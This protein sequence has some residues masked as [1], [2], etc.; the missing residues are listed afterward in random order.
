[1]SNRGGCS[2]SVLLAFIFGGIVGAVLALIYTPLPGDEARKRIREE[3]DEFGEIV[4]DGY[5]IARDRVEEG[6]GKVREFVGD[7]TDV[8]KG[9]FHKEDEEEG[10]ESEPV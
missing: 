10:E 8:L 4:K 7:K 2:I 9:A 1:M 3:A 6:V 5:D